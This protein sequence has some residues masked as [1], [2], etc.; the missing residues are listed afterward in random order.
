MMSKRITEGLITT[1]LFP[2]LSVWRTGS[3]CKARQPNICWTVSWTWN[4]YLQIT[5]NI[6]YRF[7]DRTGKESVFGKNKTRSS[8]YKRVIA[9]ADRDFRGFSTRVWCE[10]KHTTAWVLRWIAL[11]HLLGDWLVYGGLGQGP[12]DSDESSMRKDKRRFELTIDCSMTNGQT[13]CTYILYSMGSEVYLFL[14][15]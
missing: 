13:V 7:C 14:P 5:G 10:S 9:I 6:T 3:I 8:Q 12:D 11:L 2:S 4:C 1:L 15:L